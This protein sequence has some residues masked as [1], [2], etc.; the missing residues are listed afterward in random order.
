ME[1]LTDIAV[2]VRTVELGSFTAAAGELGLSKAAVSKFV[3]RLETRLGARLLNRTTRRL[4]LT[5]AGAALYQGSRTALQ[6]LEAA[7]SDVLELAGKP[8]GLL[9]VTLPELLGTGFLAPRIGAFRRAYPDIVLD[10]NL[11]NRIVDLVAERYD[12]AIRMTTLTNSALIARRLGEVSVVTVAAPEYLR[13]RG[14]PSV[15]A[16]LA[17]HDCLAYNL[18]RTPSEWHYRRGRGKHETVR[19]TGPLRSD[20]DSMLKTAALDGHGIIHMPEIFLRDELRNGKLVEL[21][22]D[23]VGSSVTLAAVFLTRSNLAPKVRVFV[24]FLV[25]QFSR[26]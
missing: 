21:L 17:H 24:D 14:V 16:D 3:S 18:D 26:S 1:N 12:L 15:P 4:S 5:E 2:F 20:N 13:V 25:Q 10:L 6:D 11:A 7:Q 8:R 9:R 19:V 23:Y 22:P